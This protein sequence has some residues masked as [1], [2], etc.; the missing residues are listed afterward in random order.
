M[1]ECRWI[2]IC[3]NGAVA[4]GAYEAGVLAQAYADCFAMNRRSE[5]PVAQIDA[6]AGASAGAVTGVVLAQALVSGA[7]PDSLTKRMRDLWIDGLDIRALLGDTKNPSRALFDA[8]AFVDLAPR[9]LYSD[10][11]I[12]QLCAKIESVPPVAL[13]VALTNVDGI[14][15]RIPMDRSEVVAGLYADY[16]PVL[17]ENGIPYRASPI[18]TLETSGTEVPGTALRWDHEVLA[19]VIA[20]AAFPLAFQSRVLNRDLRN[21]PSAVRQGPTDSPETYP[22]NYVDGGVLNNNPIGRAIDAAAYLQKRHLHPNDRRVYLVI[23]PDPIT[24][25]Q[26]RKQLERLASGAAPLGMTPIA[27]ASALVRTYFNSAL[28][29][30]LATASKVN[31]RI[32]KLREVLDQLVASGALHTSDSDEIFGAAGFAHKQ[33]IDMHRIPAKERQHP[34]AGEFAGHFGGF[35]E[36]RYREYDFAVGCLEARVWFREEFGTFEFDGMLQSGLSESDTLKPPEP[37]GFVG[38]NVELR[39]STADA[40]AGRLTTLADR[41]FKL[42][43]WLA[44]FRPLILWGLKGW[45]KKGIARVFG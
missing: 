24:E 28:Y 20:S 10:V 1:A 4:L 43:G 32:A 30:D 35:F 40:M 44:L 23:E 45:L 36:R 15:Y 17:I 22:F 12:S 11:E 9:V 7:S 33:R 37:G 38:V 14:A 26:A 39:R 2:A 42:T 6:I 21:Y 19:A 13:W 16:E 18:E 25:E 34:L 41:S 3:S 8:K 27:E 31:E 29:Q 5:K